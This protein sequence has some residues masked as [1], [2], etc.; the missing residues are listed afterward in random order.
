MSPPPSASCPAGDHLPSKRVV[1]ASASS[2]GLLGGRPLPRHFT[3][4]LFASP[5]QRWRLRPWWHAAAQPFAPAP[6][7]VRQPRRTRERLR[8]PL[9]GRALSDGAV[10]KSASWLGDG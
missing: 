9:C 7:R 10:S 5:C 6:A 8:A 2:L 4:M 3:L 1:R